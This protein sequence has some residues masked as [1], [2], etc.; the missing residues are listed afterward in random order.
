MGLTTF[1]G[2]RLRCGLMM[3]GLEMVLLFS[4]REKR[5]DGVSIHEI[6]ITLENKGYLAIN[7]IRALVYF[8]IMT[9]DNGDCFISIYP[10]IMMSSFQ[11]YPVSYHHTYTLLLK[12]IHNQE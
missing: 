12:Y 7:Y 8:L 4:R 9:K 2:V 1:L 3:D 10:F 5:M 6:N 11:R